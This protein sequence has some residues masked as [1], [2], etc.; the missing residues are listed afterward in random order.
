MRGL[1]EAFLHQ[2]LLLLHCKCILSI[3]S[4]SQQLLQST[5]QNSLMH[6][7]V[8]EG[9][10]RAGLPGSRCAEVGTHPPQALK[11]ASVTRA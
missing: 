9:S 3:L 1:K 6:P 7:A 2:Q 5:G 4:L 8:A 10:F 11:A